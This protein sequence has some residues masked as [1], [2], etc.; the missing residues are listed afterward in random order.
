MF[1][2]L[3]PIFVHFSAA[4]LV[5]G[6]G[7]EAYGILRR[8]EGIASFGSMLVLLGT[9]SLVPTVVTGFLAQ[10]SIEVPPGAEPLLAWHEG[11][12]L[13]VLAVFLSSQLWKGWF[14]GRIPPG[15]RFLYATLL[16]LGAA[17]VGYGALLGGEMVYAHGV[18]VKS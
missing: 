5:S 6:G 1:H 15:Q 7:F 17:L 3:H 18:G 10:N 2:L 4:F 8:R 11:T 14:R 16:I 12:G 13:S 9:L